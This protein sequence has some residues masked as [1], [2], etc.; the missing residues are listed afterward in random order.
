M[1]LNPSYLGTCSSEL[2]LESIA[3][4]VINEPEEEED[5]MSND[6]RVGFRGRHR[7]HLREVIDMVPPPT[8]KACSKEAQEE[9]K[10]EV[11]PMPMPSPNAEEPSSVPAAK[12]EAGPALKGVF[13]GAASIEEVLEQKDTPAP[14]S[15]P[16]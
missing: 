7:K 15:L 10:R 14:A 12:K 6:L 1:R 9:P 2:K 4:G 13:G 11:P 3:F 5:D 16:S 8:K